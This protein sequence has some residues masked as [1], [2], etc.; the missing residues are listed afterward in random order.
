MEKFGYVHTI[1]KLLIPEEN[2]LNLTA[3][4][5]RVTRPFYF[6]NKQRLRR[7]AGCI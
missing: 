3:T 7:V 5:W 4:D 2:K 1:L 6:E